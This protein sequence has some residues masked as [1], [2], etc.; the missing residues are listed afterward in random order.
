MKLSAS[1]IAIGS[2]ITSGE[3]V[4]SN[5]AWISGRLEDLGLPIKCHIAVPDDREIVLAALEQMVQSTDVVFVTG[6]LGPTSDDFTRE[7]VASFLG[8]KLK[9]DE[10]AW[11]Q[12]VDKLNQRGLLV[13]ENH[14]QQCFFPYEA[15]LLDNPVGTAP[16]FYAVKNDKRFFILP[17]PP[18]EIQGMWEKSIFPRLQT[19]SIM[20]E[21]ELYIWNCLGVPE[22]EVAEVVEKT[23]SGSGFQLGYRA[24]VPYVKVK[25]WAPVNSDSEPWL[26]KL[27]KALAPWLVGV[28]NTDPL[29]TW[30][31]SLL[32][33]DQVHIL[34]YITQGRLASRIEGV[35]EKRKD[36]QE[37]LKNM[38]IV[39]H[40]KPG[41]NLDHERLMQG[42]CSFLLSPVAEGNRFVV[43]SRL[44][45]NQLNVEKEM[46]HRLSLR[47]KRGRF[48]CTEEAIY[49]WSEFL[50]SHP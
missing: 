19:L 8:K 38:D 28:G 32:K 25:V 24:N 16:G 22:S 3:V 9:F 17:G 13:R 41:E 4:N 21:K 29:E 46:P 10:R 47:S 45:D 1:I 49:L 44:G 33:Y 7:V 26:N 30:L 11:V 37:G 20:K 12:L 18:R 39:I 23:M 42:S 50:K 35:R 43:R 36:L 40:L 2:E 27:D 48:Y 14:K 6:G 15:E 34:D 31:E 5:A